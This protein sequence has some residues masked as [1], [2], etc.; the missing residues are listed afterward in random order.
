MKYTKKQIHAWKT[1]LTN[2]RYR[3]VLFDGGARSGKTKLL[4]D[5]VFAR[6]FQFPGAKQLVA[7]KFRTNAKN[8]IWTDT[9]KKYI[10][11]Y[12]EMN[13]TLFRTLDSELKIYFANGSEILVAGLDNAERVEKVRGTEYCTIY[14]NEATE[15]SYTTMNEV[16]TR[17]SQRVFDKNGNE[18]VP[19][20]LLDCNPRG[21]R[22]WLYS[23]GV[24]HVDP[25]SGRTLPNA[26]IWKRVHWSAYDNQENLSKEYLEELENLPEIQKQRMLHGKW[27]SAEGQVYSDFRE[28]IHVVSP[29]RI[30]DD[31]TKIRSIDFGFTN[32]FVCLWG[33]VDHDGKLY[34][35]REL[36]KAGIL[37]SVHAET[38]KKLSG[39]ERYLMT[40][41]DHDAEER[42]ELNKNGIPTEAAK[43]TVQLGIQ[44]VQKRFRENRIFIFPSCKQLLS[45]IDSYSWLPPSEERN[46]CEEPRKLDDHAMDAMRYMVMAVDENFK[47]NIKNKYRAC[48]K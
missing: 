29:F 5:Y 32:P 26:E 18:A 34:I 22:H 14:L 16:L 10:A 19:K 6:A 35:Y 37:T 9:I 25:E 7:R 38:I 13:G 48:L 28:E 47:S 31:W 27:V 44:T 17:L 12:P 46:A 15:L 1:V 42:A 36:Y 23:V 11:Q 24:K 21:P 3:R 4:M 40:V 43:K 45:E 41:A 8:S 20:L 39:N 33:A 2:N 30:P